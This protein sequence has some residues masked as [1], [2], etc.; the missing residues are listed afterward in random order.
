MYTLPTPTLPAADSPQRERRGW[1]GDAQLSCETNIHNFFMAAPYTSFVQQIDD[2]QV[3]GERG[4]KK[5]T[6]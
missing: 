6:P 2:A 5:K 1:L 4:K 3:R